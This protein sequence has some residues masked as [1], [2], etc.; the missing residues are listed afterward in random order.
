MLAGKPYLRRFDAKISSG[1]YLYFCICVCIQSLIDQMQFRHHSPMPKIVIFLKLAQNKVNF[2]SSPNYNYIEMYCHAKKNWKNL[3]QKIQLDLKLPKLHI[4]TRN[5]TIKPNFTQRNV[6]KSRQFFHQNGQSGYFWRT[7]VD[8]SV[9]LWK[10]R[11][12]HFT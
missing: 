11:Q 1:S 9:K 7:S 8:D 10:F 5:K 12:R 2:F 3:K 4:F 6:R